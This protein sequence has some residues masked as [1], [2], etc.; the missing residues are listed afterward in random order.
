MIMIMMM[1]MMM[2]MTMMVDDDD[3]GGDG[4]DDGGTKCISSESKALSQ[5]P[6]VYRW[7]HKPARQRAELTLERRQ[8]TLVQTNLLVSIRFAYLRVLS[9]SW[10]TI[11]TGFKQR[12]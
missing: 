9:L 1:I 7:A 4:D 2:M 12:D 5:V 6:Q 3:D 11:V 8:H 10:Q